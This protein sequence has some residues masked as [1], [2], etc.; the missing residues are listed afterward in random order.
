M[1][2]NGLLDDLKYPGMGLSELLLTTELKCAFY[3]WAMRAGHPLTLFLAM[4]YGGEGFGLVSLPQLWVEPLALLW[5]GPF[6][7]M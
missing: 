3:F 6:C 1:V 2:P 7:L 5:L 4:D